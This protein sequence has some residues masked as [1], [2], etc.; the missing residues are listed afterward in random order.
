MGSKAAKSLALLPSHLILQENLWL[1]CCIA[2][3][4]IYLFSFKYLQQF[5]YFTTNFAE[6]IY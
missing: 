6:F 3:N 2:K 5:K 1:L 4:E